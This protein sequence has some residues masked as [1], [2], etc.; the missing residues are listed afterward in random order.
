VKITDVR[1][2]NILATR[3]TVG[4]L[5]SRCVL[6]DA[7]S[8]RSGSPS[9]DRMLALGVCFLHLVFSVAAGITPDE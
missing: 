5:S 6:T 2:K 1:A 4:T 9:P 7:Q 3:E 8:V